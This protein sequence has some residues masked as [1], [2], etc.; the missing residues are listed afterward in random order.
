MKNKHGKWESLDLRYIHLKMI[1]SLE[2]INDLLVVL[3][4]YGELTRSDGL[5]SD[6]LRSAQHAQ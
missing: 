1:A 2:I 4:Y 6:G 3:I 5:Q